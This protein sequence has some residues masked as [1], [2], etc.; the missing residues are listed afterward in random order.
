[1]CSIVGITGEETA[2]PLGI[3]SLLT[4][5]G[6]GSDWGGIASTENGEIQRYVKQ[7]PAR[8]L[9]SKYGQ[10]KNPPKGSFM[11][12][13]TRYAT[14]GRQGKSNAQPLVSKDKKLAIAHNG[15]IVEADKLRK[16]LKGQGVKFKS[17]SDSEVVLRML[18]NAKGESIVDKVLSVLEKISGTYALVILWNEHLI[19]AC[20]SKAFHPLC[21]G[22]FKDGG[23]V[24]ASEDTA[25][26]TIGARPIQDV[27]PGQVIMVTP[28]K[29]VKTY[30]LSNSKRNTSRTAHCAMNF[31][32][33]GLPTSSLWGVNVNE[34]R[35]AFGQWCFQEMLERGALPHVDIVTPILDSGAIATLKFAK[36]L[37]HWRTMELVRKGGLS[38]LEAVDDDYLD[39]FKFGIFR[40]REAGR[41]FQLPTQD[42]R[43]VEI[44][45]KHF[46]NS[47]VVKNKRVLVGDDSKVRGTTARRISRMLRELGA[48]EV[49]FVI[50]SP[51]VLDSCFYG[52]VSTKAKHLLPAT[53]MS[54]EEMTK[55][56]EADSLYFISPEGFTAVLD[57]FTAGCCTACWGGPQPIEIPGS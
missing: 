21:L 49:H 19:G 10:E 9:A 17:S 45:L 42:D 14:E 39:P 20:D 23:H 47:G 25:I 48:L 37:G 22:A 30:W 38:E 55:N 3:I 43:D 44:E 7:G 56:I 8:K 52:G 24:F 31:V 51:S 27:K 6:R 11:I 28:D 15:E 50:F 40:A 46:V 1:M 41:N 4:M 36:A 57:R 32:Y 35:E 5:E 26:R 18:E 33:T 12:G 16:E 13:H 54:H 34:I 29:D 53:T 2:V